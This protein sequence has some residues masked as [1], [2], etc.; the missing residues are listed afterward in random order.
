M[1]AAVA[2]LKATKSEIEFAKAMMAV[3]AMTLDELDAWCAQYNSIMAALEESDQK[4]Q[5]SLLPAEQQAAASREPSQRSPWGLIKR[6]SSGAKRQN[7]LVAID[8]I[9]RPISR[10][11]S[12]E[13]LRKQEESNSKLQLV[14]EEL[15]DTEVRYG[16]SIALLQTH[17]GARL[18]SSLKGFLPNLASLVDL[19]AQMQEGMVAAASAHRDAALAQALGTQL[20]ALAPFFKLFVAYCTAFPKAMEAL[21]SMPSLLKTVAEAEV[22]IASA[23]DAVGAV[24]IFALLIKPVQ[25]L[26]QYPLLFREVVQA[27][28]ADS[29]GGAD[30]GAD[31]GEEELRRVLAL[32]EGAA[33]D[34]NERVRGAEVEARLWTELS[35]TE[36]RGLLQ[37]VCPSGG[38]G[39]GLSLRTE[40]AVDFVARRRSVSITRSLSFQRRKQYGEGRHGKLFVFSTALLLSKSEGG[41]NCLK[42]V[43]VWSLDDV[44]FEIRDAEPPSE[45][46]TMLLQ[47]LCMA[48][49]ADGDAR[50]GGNFSLRCSMADAAR[51]RELL[52]ELKEG[53]RRRSQ[54]ASVRASCDYG[55]LDKCSTHSVPL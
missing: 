44:A 24:S 29:G 20:A 42:A 16:R 47:Q 4:I 27:M 37:T 41:A 48:D 26:C 10:R 18:P 38:G 39:G 21:R 32:L 17:F 13:D 15:I 11:R 31:C 53:N 19:S 51:M 46:A 12:S 1:K 45:K 55:A 54:L 6:A 35:G 40:I 23:D 25:R 50:G 8:T 14:C 30:G 2:P 49:P 36:W 43:A 3:D 33:A 34:V 52:G 9:P 5:S 22:A 7:S 28:A